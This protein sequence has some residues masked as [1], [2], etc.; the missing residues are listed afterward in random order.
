[1][2][3]IKSKTEAFEALKKE[4]SVVLFAQ[5]N[6]LHCNVV[7]NS[8]LNIEKKYPLICFYKTEDKL[9]FDAYVDSFPTLVFYENGAEVGR[10]I[11]SGSIHKLKEMLNLW[12]VK[13]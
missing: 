8:I 11:G 4:H 6:C 13:L 10:V 1:M 5:E 9:L 7:E 2:K 12:I 3:E